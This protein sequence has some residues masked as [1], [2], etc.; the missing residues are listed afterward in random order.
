[1]AGCPF[2]YRGAVLRLGL[3]GISFVGTVFWVASPEAAVILYSLQRGWHPLAAGGVAGAGQA[4]ALAMLAAFG[5][6][7]RRRWAWFDRQCD[8]LRARHGQRLARSAPVLGVSSG[9]LGLPP[10]SATVLLAPG[11]GLRVAG[12]LPLLFLARVVRF[13]VVAALARYA[14]LA[15]AAGV[16]G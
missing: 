16:G 11:L 13:T 15:L 3:F 4:A 14:H 12:L 5:D 8:R 2:D 10:V 9:L 7:L 6:Q 1:M